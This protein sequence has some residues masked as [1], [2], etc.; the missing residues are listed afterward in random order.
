MENKL[1]ELAALVKE[2]RESQ[3]SFFRSKHRNHLD[4]SRELEAKVDNLVKEILDTQI[5]LF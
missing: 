4:R 1:N 2:M 3:T 5:K